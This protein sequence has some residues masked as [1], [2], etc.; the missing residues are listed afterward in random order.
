MPKSKTRKRPAAAPAAPRLPQNPERATLAVLRDAM[1]LVQRSEAQLDAFRLHGTD[2]AQF[3]QLVEQHLNR[4]AGV[5]GLLTAYSQMT[6][7]P[8]P[9]SA[10][11]AGK[12]LT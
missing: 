3:D 10:E 5:L 12:V 11:I 4:R 1:Q 7:M 2:G 9:R 8:D 6:G